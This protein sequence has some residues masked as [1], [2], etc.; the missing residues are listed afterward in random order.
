MKYEWAN[1]SGSFPVSAQVVGETLKELASAGGGRLT[2]EAVVNAARPKR[3]PL[4]NCFT[5][6]DV[7]AGELYRQT[8]AARLIRSVRVIQRASKDAEPQPIT[9]F[10]L[11]KDEAGSHFKPVVSTRAEQLRKAV[12]TALDGLM[13][14]REK[15]EPYQEVGKW[16]ARVKGCEADVKAVREAAQRVCAELERIENGLVESLM[17]PKAQPARD[18]R[19]AP[20]V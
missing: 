11:G 14:A 8:E 12:N 15:L 7:K 20:S 17:P 10:Q 9:I 1:E 5:W 6:D 3:A 4:H 2:P 16:C 19:R 18:A 13:T